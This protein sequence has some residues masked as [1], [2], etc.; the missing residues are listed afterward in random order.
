M[1]WGSF[2]K[3]ALRLGGRATKATA[4]SAGSAVIHPQQTLKGLGSATKTAVVGGSLGYIGWEKLTT[5]KSVVGIVSDAVIGKDATK[6]IGDTVS[7]IGEGVKDLKDS[8]TGLTDNVNGAI[9][10]LDSKWSGMSGFLQAMFSGRGGD[11]ISNFFSN[12]GKGNVSGLN[13]VGLV[14]SALLVFGRFGWLGK[15][16]G[17]VL[18]MMMIGNNANL[19]QVLGGAKNKTGNNAQEETKES[20]VEQSTG[21]GRHR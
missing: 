8:V 11:M 21:G 10:D 17:A 19:S 15:I 1:G 5:D 6:K 4:H 14:V 18:A 3:A 9:T 13:L 7:G 2:L 20:Q 16:A 12:L